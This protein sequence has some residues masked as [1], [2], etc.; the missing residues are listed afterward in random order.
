MFRRSLRGM[1]RPS[2]QLLSDS[3]VRRWKFKK[4]LTSIGE[5]LFRGC[6]EDRAGSLEIQ[7]SVK[8]YLFSALNEDLDRLSNTRVPWPSFLLNF[9]YGME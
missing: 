7:L 3:L 2:L 8:K 5:M 1:R 4:K 9:Y 6:G